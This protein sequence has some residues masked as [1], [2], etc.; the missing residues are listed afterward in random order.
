M[1]MSY[2]EET[3]LAMTDE[4]IKCHSEQIEQIIVTLL[5][6]IASIRHVCATQ[7]IW[8]DACSYVNP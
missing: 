2:L 3:L 4:D 5:Y 7:R 1:V 8:G 6:L